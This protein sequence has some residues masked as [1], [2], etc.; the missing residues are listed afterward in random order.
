MARSIPFLTL[1]AAAALFAQPPVAPTPERVGAPRGQNVAGYNIVNSFETGYRFRDVSGNLG[2]Y[3]SD[4]NF[5]NGVRLL[6]SRLSIHSRE[7]QGAWFDELLLNTQGLGNDPYQIAT[8]RAVKNRLYQYNL[9]WRLNDYFNPGLTIANG[10][11]ALNTTR[12]LQDHDLTLLPA[13]NIR[14]FLGYSRNHQYGPALSTIQLFDSRGA[15]FPLFSDVRRLQNEYR[16]GVELKASAYRLNV[17]RVWEN[18]REDTQFG[19][20]DQRPADPASPARLDAF[21][22]DEP[23]HGNTPSW[24]VALFRETESWLALNARFTWSSGERNF[25]F[26]ESATGVDRFARNR[27]IL[28]GGQARRPVA[29]ANLTASLFPATSLTV[30][31]HTGYHHTRIEG[32]SFLRQFDN[33]SLSDDFLAFQFLGVRALTN[34]TDLTWRPRRRLTFFTGYRF[35]DRRIRSVEQITSGPFQDRLPAQQSNRLHAGVA[36]I[37][38]SPV[39]GLT[40]VVDSELGRADRPFF[41]ISERNYHTLGGRIQYKRGTLFLSGLA[42]SLYNTNPASFSYHSARQRNYSGDVS[43][44]PAGWF[45]FDASYSKLHIDALTTLAYFFESRL[46]E[47]DRS[48]YISNIHTGSL[49]VR[50]QLRRRAD[51][52]LGYTRVQD[53]GDGRPSL[54]TPRSTAP[55]VAPFLIGAQVF[56]LSFES[57]LAR[58][59]VPLHAR[60]RLNFGYQFYRYREEFTVAQNYRAHTGYASV[61]WSF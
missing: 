20:A 42:R 32:D 9:T 15:V 1:A 2:R 10:L 22:R 6:S 18:F 59:S 54:F 52:F 14:F 53:R 7:G 21:R 27:Q 26:D 36:G 44:T 13:S 34:S 11:H 37:R 35:T 5:G 60:L 50:V 31:N 41:P 47:S 33:A 51:L 4:V 46:V 19:A 29:T 38:V 58:V 17:S 16:L 61:L 8:F 23:Y 45:S 57:P 49:G 56:P 24:R 28:I 3:R 43:W 40:V 30:T 48:A 12:R 39:A 55:G 25:I